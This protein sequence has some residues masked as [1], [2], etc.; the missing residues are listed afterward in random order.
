MEHENWK[1]V[2]DR[3]FSPEEQAHWAE[4]MADAARR[5]RPGGL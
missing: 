5:L 3:Y 4:R 2:T 1:K